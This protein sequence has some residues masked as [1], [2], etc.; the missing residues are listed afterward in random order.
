M[1][2]VWDRNIFNP[3]QKRLILCVNNFDRNVIN[4]NTFVGQC[5][6]HYG[7]IIELTEPE[8][9]GLEAATYA[10]YWITFFVFSVLPAP[11]SP[12]HKIDWSSRSSH[13]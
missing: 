3:K 13:I 4:L 12:V 5:N 7:Q 2:K 8:P 11:D 1:F 10:K 9:F 6:N